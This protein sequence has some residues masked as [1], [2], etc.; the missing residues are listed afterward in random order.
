MYRGERWAHPFNNVPRGGASR[1]FRCTTT[2]EH[3][4][5]QYVWAI[6][7][8]PLIGGTPNVRWNPSLERIASAS[9]PI[10]PVPM[11]A[12]AAVVPLKATPLDKLQDL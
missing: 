3:G 9:E 10:E 12:S 4:V 6:G 7:E 1:V 8:C 11:E 5:E 2:N